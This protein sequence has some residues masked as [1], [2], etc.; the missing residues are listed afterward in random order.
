MCAAACIIGAGIIC[1]DMFV[2]LFP[3]MH[4]F[5]IAESDTFLSA[6]LSLSFGVMLFSSLYSMLPQS[7]NYLEHG[8][9][10]PRTASY[11]LISLF[12]AGAIGIQILSRIL[13]DFIPSHVVDCDHT[14]DEEFAAPV[15]E[16]M[17]VHAHD[18]SHTNGAPV[19]KP[20]N[21]AHD[22]D[23]EITP[24]L[25]RTTSITP[26]KQ[27]NTSTSEAGAIKPP[28]WNRSEIEPSSHRPSLVPRSLTRTFSRFAVGQTA[29][30]DET[31]PCM[32]Y[33]DPCGQDCFKVVQRRG[34]ILPSHGSTLSRP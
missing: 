28:S 31:G 9:Y 7:K 12:L 1:V 6:S 15:T 17:E 18:D 30:C 25:S 8:G 32:G 22:E 16:E 10:S 21:A 29:N 14:H 26:P 20:M 3:R 24:L 27:G 19:V 5:S 34:V 4:S 2:R 23:D 11:L 33:S 13:H